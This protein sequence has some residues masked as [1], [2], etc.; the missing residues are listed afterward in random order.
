[1]PCCVVSQIA[2]A[3]EYSEW[4]DGHFDYFPLD[5]ELGLG[6]RH[7]VR[8]MEF[9]PVHKRELTRERRVVGL[10]PR[11]IYIF[12]QRFTH[13][14]TRTAFQLAA[15]EDGAKHIVEEA[16]LETE[17]V[18]HFAA[19]TRDESIIAKHV[20]AF[21][22]FLDEDV[23]GIPRRAGFKSPGGPSIISKAARAEMN[24]LAAEQ[25]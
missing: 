9:R 17:W 13:S 6:E 3:V 25:A 24:R 22:K 2:T 15:F 18:E 21:H 20:K 8:L 1:M 16:E 10:T 7:A 4:P 23:D 14:L 12:Q 19:D 5:H 11:G